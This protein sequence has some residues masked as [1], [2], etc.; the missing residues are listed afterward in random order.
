MGGCIDQQ[1]TDVE[2]FDHILKA[3]EFKKGL[4]EEVMNC[5]M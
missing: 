4:G 2:A 5:L 1:R 3:E